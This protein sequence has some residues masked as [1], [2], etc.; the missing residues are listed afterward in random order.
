MT[1]LIAAEAWIQGLPPS[2]TRSQAIDLVRIEANRR[3]PN[4]KI[5]CGWADRR[6]GFDRYEEVDSAFAIIE[7]YRWLSIVNEVKNADKEVA[8][9]D[10][11]EIVSVG[12]NVGD[13][14]Y[15]HHVAILF[16]TKKLNTWF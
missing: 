7:I 11:L 15:D 1:G 8:M 3:Y 16:S 5:D 2:L 14:W 12:R 6:P 10:V 13:P 4:Y 9:K